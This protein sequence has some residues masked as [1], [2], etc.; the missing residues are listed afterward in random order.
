MIYNDDLGAFLKVPE[1]MGARAARKIDQLFFTRLMSNPG[2][3]FS[4]AHENYKEGADTVLS[5]DSL[6]V[7]IQMFMDQTDADGQPI[8][9]SP[10][11]LLVPSDSPPLANN[12][13]G[14]TN[15]GVPLAITLTASDPDGVSSVAPL[16]S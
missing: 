8:N 11:Y 5:G 4:E 2:S 6:G 14:I 15:Q 3:L 16:L 13:N 1:G 12:Q 7:A 9:V 10:K